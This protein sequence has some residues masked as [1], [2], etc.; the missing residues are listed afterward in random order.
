MIYLIRYI[1]S[2]FDIYSV[3]SIHIYIS[4]VCYTKSKNFIDAASLLL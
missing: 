2:V 3:I 1:E 4:K